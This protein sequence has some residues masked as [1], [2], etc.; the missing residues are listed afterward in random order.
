MALIVPIITFTGCGN[1]KRKAV[2]K[3]I[4]VQF[5]NLKNSSEKEDGVKFTGYKDLK[6]EVA[7]RHDSIMI[8]SAKASGITKG[9]EINFPIEIVY[10]ELPESGGELLGINLVPQNESIIEMTDKMIKDLA[11]S[12]KISAEDRRN[13]SNQKDNIC[14]MGA[15]IFLQSP[16]AIVKNINTK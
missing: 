12:D 10:C 1:S 14:A 11:T 5:V 8:Y 2:E 7:I 15:M 3:Q 4:D 13:L 6:L 16:K 9:A